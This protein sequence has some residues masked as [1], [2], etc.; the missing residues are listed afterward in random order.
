[1]DKVLLKPDFKELFYKMNI[2]LF[3]NLED[4]Y[5]DAEKKYNSINPHN[6]NL[7][8]ADRW[9]EIDPIF[10]TTQSLLDEFEKGLLILENKRKLDFNEEGVLEDLLKK[11]KLRYYIPQ[12]YR[13]ELFFIINHITRKM[14][15][16]L[17]N[18]SCSPDAR[19]LEEDVEEDFF[20]IILEIIG[21]FVT[22]TIPQDFHNIK[23]RTLTLVGYILTFCRFFN[24]IDHSYDIGLKEYKTML[25][26]NVKK[27]LIIPFDKRT[28]DQKEADIK[29]LKTKK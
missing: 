14:E 3:D 25:R 16:H 10:I 29:K 9:D 7:A 8:K 1:M 23:D 28:I 13:H 11:G 4:V 15:S 20:Y 6:K 22:E 2:Q 24:T 26:D 27:K 5:Y 12:K 21:Q 19:L 17:I 18:P